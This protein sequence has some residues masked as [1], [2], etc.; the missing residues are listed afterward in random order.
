VWSP[1]L[2]V[3][4]VRWQCDKENHGWREGPPR[5]FPA[6]VSIC[7][8]GLHP[9]VSQFRTKK[10]YCFPLENAS[11]SLRTFAGI[12]GLQGSNISERVSLR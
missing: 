3:V 6:K 11:L 10:E 9:P 5:P 4:F 8:P 2:D 12:K 7:W 1:R